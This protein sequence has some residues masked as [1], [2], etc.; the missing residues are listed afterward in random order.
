[1][2]GQIHAPA[3]LPPREKRQCQLYRRL[4]GLQIR[5]LLSIEQK[6]VYP[7]G[8]RPLDRQPA[9]SRYTDL[10][11]PVP[12]PK[13]RF[14]LK[15]NRM[16]VKLKNQQ[17]YM[18]SKLRP[19][20]RYTKYKEALIPLNLNSCYVKCKPNLDLNFYLKFLFDVV[21]ILRSPLKN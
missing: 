9:G 7:V 1:M 21:C 16:M 20:V 13:I 4:G 18:S 15:V 17:F 14:Y 8:H 12:S 2:S 11:I 10:A 3:A 19:T 6:V 5:S